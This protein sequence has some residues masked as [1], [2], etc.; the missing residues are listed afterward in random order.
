MHSIV[1]NIQLKQ[2]QINGSIQKVNTF[3]VLFVLDC[4]CFN[5]FFFYFKQ[6]NLKKLKN[7]YEIS[8]KK[9]KQCISI[10][11]FIYKQSKP[12]FSFQIAFFEHIFFYLKCIEKNLM[13][14]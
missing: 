3:E 10:S 4:R 8:I 14:N 11:E 7:I 2:I 5:H 9:V 1:N 12:N 13:Q 6:M